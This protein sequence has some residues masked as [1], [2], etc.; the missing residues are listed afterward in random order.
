MS[1]REWGKVTLIEFFVNRKIQFLQYEI[2]ILGFGRWMVTAERIKKYIDNI[3]VL[4]VFVLQK[5]FETGVARFT[6]KRINLVRSF[7]ELPAVFVD[8]RLWRSAPFLSHTMGCLYPGQ[9]LAFH[10]IEDFEYLGQGFGDP[11]DID[12]REID[13]RCAS[14]LTKADPFTLN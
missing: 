7:V 6:E 11:L 12:I 8:N 4:G 13:S 9:T 10:F 3:A 14:M 2:L 5:R 1:S